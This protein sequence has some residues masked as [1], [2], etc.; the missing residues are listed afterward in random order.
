MKLKS[1]EKIL[2]FFVF[3]AIAIWAF[4]HFYYTPQ[5]RKIQQLKEEIKSADLRLRESPFFAQ[6]VNGVE[7]EVASLEEKIKIIIDKTLKDRESRA[8][9]RYLARDSS[10]LQMKLISLDIKEEE[11]LPPAEEKNT[12]ILDYKRVSALMVFNT[13]YSALKTYLKDIEELPFLLS[14]DHIQIEK[15]NEVPLPLKAT[16][17]LDMLIM[18]SYG[19]GR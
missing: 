4:D 12:S 19:A 9:L 13:T 16:I 6:N 5:K 3:I 8:F 2:I 10:R 15:N 14:V 11:L 18:S 1:R 7:S 17:G